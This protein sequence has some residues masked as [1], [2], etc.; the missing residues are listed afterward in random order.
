MTRSAFRTRKSIESWILWLVMIA[1]QISLIIGFTGYQYAD[2]NEYVDF[3][4][5]SIKNGRLFYPYADE[6]YT[7]YLHAP[8]YINYLI[9]VLSLT[10]S[11]IFV[12]VL[13]AVY[14]HVILFSCKYI[15]RRLV[16]DDT[17]DI[18]QITFCIYY[19]IGMNGGIV[20]TDT[21]LVFGALLFAALAMTLKGNTGLTILAGVLLGLSNW[22]RPV[23]FV[24]IPFV[25][26]IMIRQREAWKKRLVMIMVSFLTTI[27]VIGFVSYAHCGKFVFQ[28]TIT[29]INLLIGNNPRADGNNTYDALAEGGIGYVGD[30][31]T[32]EWTYDDYQVLW[33]DRA[34]EWMLQN[35]GSVLKLIPRKFAYQWTVDTYW[36]SAYGN[37]ETVTDTL[38]YYKTIWNKIATNDG[39]TLTLMDLTTVA[40]ECIYLA[41]LIGF[42]VSV[43]FQRRN[44][45]ME[46]WGIYG[47]IV[48]GLGMNTIMA[49]CGRFHFVYMPLIVMALSLNLLGGFDRAGRQNDGK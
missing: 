36:C 20:Q 5:S 49:G 12:Y 46:Y 2:A 34:I 23:V 8:G 44:T 22:I 13:N 21:E 1:I 45:V 28:S 25:I 15:V 37:N 41:V 9:A 3:A 29:G 7:W 48:V 4:Y 30:L 6:I 40:H 43:F 11:M 27:T 24:F 10:N 32:S 33:K 26:W 18:F 14:I 19:M 17:A 39:K 47:V 16:T 35:P 38:D 42:A 31:D